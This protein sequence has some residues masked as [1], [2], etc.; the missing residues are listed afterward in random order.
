VQP[1][2]IGALMNVARMYERLGDTRLAEK[3]LW[4]AKA[5]LPKVGEMTFC[6]KIMRN[7]KINEIL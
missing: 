6:L 4:K 5:F 7:S 1:N 3:I 2:D